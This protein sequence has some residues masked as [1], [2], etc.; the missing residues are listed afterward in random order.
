MGVE[1][2]FKSLQ[3]TKSFPIIAL[4]GKPK[5]G[6]TLCSLTASDKFLLG[7]C[8]VDDIGVI[9]CEKDALAGAKQF[10]VDIKYWID[11]TAY[12]ELPS[13]A[14]DECL[15]AAFAKMQELAKAGKIK[16]LVFDSVSTQDKIWK[17]PLTKQGLGTY[18]VLNHLLAKH[19][20]LIFARLFAL[21]CPSII[22]FHTRVLG[23]MDDAKRESLG[24][25]QGE[26]Q[27]IDVSGW[28]APALYRAQCSAILPI[29]K[30]QVKGKPSEYW[31]YPNGVAGLESGCRYPEL[32]LQEKVKADFKEIFKLIKLNKEL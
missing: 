22:L 11:L 7:S 1:I 14:Y 6:K 3:E 31:L 29:K 26:S 19:R 25:D 5:E 30:T 8:M 15:A 32:E 13:K 24:L 2:G 28:D 4:L 21:T 18:E 12:A 27:I 9:T 17:T 23:K 20:E 16:A 10:G